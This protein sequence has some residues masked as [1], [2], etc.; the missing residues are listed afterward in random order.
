MSPSE[1]T[2]SGTMY[3]LLAPGKVFEYE[4]V[5]L[6]LVSNRRVGAMARVYRGRIAKREQDAGDR[7][8]QDVVVAARQ[9]GAPDRSG[10]QRISHEE[11]RSGLALLSQLKTHAAWSVTGRVMYADLVVAKTQGAQVVKDV[12]WRRLFD[13]EAEHLPLLDRLLVQR[14]IVFMEI[15]AGVQC[16]FDERDARNVIDVRVRKQDMRHFETVILNRAK[17]CASPITRID[18]DAFAR[19]LAADDEPILVKRRAGPDLE[20]HSITIVSR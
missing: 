7:S 19:A 20:N 6:A 10:E 13:R 1:Q 4:R 12:D 8:H 11:M 5:R 9:V 18:D 17:Q 16:V 3:R 14:Q 15:D 2:G